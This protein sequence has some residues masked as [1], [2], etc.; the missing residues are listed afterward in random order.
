[1]L[2]IADLHI[3]SY[4]SRATSK[5]LNLE[6]INKWA[7]IK[8]LKVVA[9][10]DIT[11]PKWLE[12]LQEKLVESHNGLYRL[13][14]EY[15]REAQAE[16]PGSCESDVYF[17]PSGEVST[18][19]KKGD[20]V[21]KVHSVIFMP[22]LEAVQKFQT[23]LDQ[24]GNIHSDGR[25]ILGLDTRDL[26][27]ITLETDPR[28][29]F[30]PAHI[31]TPWFSILGSKSGFDSIEECFEDLTPHI[32]ALE[33]GLSSDPPMNWRLSMLDSYV[34]VSNSDA[35]SPAKLAREA[36]MFNTDLNYDAMFAS[37]KHPNSDAFRGTVEFF[38]QEGKY[39]LDGHRKCGVRLEPSQTKA[40]K[41]L[42]PVCGKPVVLGVSYRVEELAD[43]SE[44]YTPNGSKAFKSLIPLPEVLA[45]LLNVGPQT[46]RVSQ[47]YYTLLN[48]LGS[49]LD[50]LI[51]RSISEIQTATGDLP[52]E[53]I[54]RMREGNIHTSPGYDG[55]YGIIRVFEEGERLEWLQQG[56]LFALDATKK[57]TVH[58]SP[59]KSYA[60]NNG[61][62]KQEP[63]PQEKLNPEQQAAISHRGSP[64][65]IQAG[66]GTGKTRTL[67]QRITELVNKDGIEPRHILA[68]TFTNKA[69]KE[70]QDRLNQQL[71]GAAQSMTVKTFHAFGVAFLREQE[72]FFHRTKEFRILSPEDREFQTFLTQSIAEKI[73]QTTWDHVSRLK[74]QG[75]TPQTIPKN[76]SQSL[77]PN[78]EKIYESYEEALIEFNA[79]DFDDLVIY[80]WKLLAQDPEL[81]RRFLQRYTA[82]SV[83]EFQDINRSQ[84]EL[85]R[86]FAIAATDVCV[87][88]DP[89]QAIYGF[90]GA[91]SEF[92]SQFIKDFPHAKTIR[93]NQN[94]RCA[95]NIVTASVQLLGRNIDD[96]ALWSD[97]S[98]E[99]RVT[100]DSTPTERA[101]AEYI[102]E[103]IETHLGGTTFFSFDS[104][105]V[106]ERTESQS[107]RFSDFAILLRSRRQFPPIEEA[108]HRSGIPFHMIET[109]AIHRHPFVQFALT[110]L[111]AVHQNNPKLLNDAIA[112][113]NE[114]FGVEPELPEFLFQSPDSHK[115]MVTLAGYI[116]DDEENAGIRQWFKHIVDLSAKNQFTLQNME[117]TL[118]LYRQT[119]L[120]DTKTDRLYIMTLHASKGLEF[121]VVFIPGCEEGII[122]HF[123][124]GQRVDIEEERRL[125]YVGMT[126]AKRHLYLIHA[127]KRMLYGRKHT[128]ES[129]H[130]LRHISESLISTEKKVYTRKKQ[131]NQLELF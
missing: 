63:K 37:L 88:G 47:H 27:E 75:F 3:H 61:S 111:R 128:Q 13:K 114:R 83:D 45:E 26:L 18:I 93:L 9:T 99:V 131:T 85:F 23:R 90:R 33:T 16:V 46:K 67:V 117:D 69:A 77:P 42:C 101:E 106:D 73:T 65:I 35:H 102:V 44:G 41:G 82:V 74:R 5:Q 130:F 66:P 53:A 120:F 22:S 95:Q 98:P 72:M 103:K 126:R 25:P 15:S 29:H 91:S 1:M 68:I 124:P 64:L 115:I 122:P 116:P 48:E 86:I 121:P 87:I 118:S 62:T 39:H 100:I 96:S 52:A 31:W 92:F 112:L 11:H 110:T 81:R 10:G 60:R 49:E 40:H 127:K 123:F 107:F 58:D 21:R 20:K 2:F 113:V 30:I 14:P 55:E 43:R 51:N 28:A 54:K 38:P 108:L 12:E 71:G 17:I 78:I 34:L 70:M 109:S 94:Y 36:N 7:Q 59:R 79:V 119:D 125:L 56:R 24:I 57:N 129:S 80:P 76:I 32:F 89:D 6:H 50:I 8:G 19:Y 84:Y 4:Y 105:R 97:I 104:T